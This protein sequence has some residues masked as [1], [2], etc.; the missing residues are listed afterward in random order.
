MDKPESMKVL[1]PQSIRRELWMR[2]LAM[3][4]VVVVFTI[5]GGWII[6]RQVTELRHACQSLSDGNVAFNAF[7][8]QQI[9]NVNN[10]TAITPAQ[11]QQALTTYGQIHLA[12]PH[13]HAGLL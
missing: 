13:C 10:S 12:A 3:F 11:K 7:I 2:Q 8:T 1:L 4:L 5:I 6:D 9:R